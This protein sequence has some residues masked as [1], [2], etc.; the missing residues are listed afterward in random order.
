[1]YLLQ[2]KNALKVYRYDGCR[3]HKPMIQ[4]TDAALSEF[5]TQ[6]LWE[7]FCSHQPGFAIRYMVY[8]HY[9]SKKWVVKP[10][11][12][13]GVDFLLYPQGGASRGHAQF[14]VQI[15]H[16][17][18]LNASKHVD[19]PLPWVLSRVLHQVAKNFVMVSVEP[20]QKSEYGDSDVLALLANPPPSLDL[21]FSRF[22][23]LE[24]GISRFC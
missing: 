11:L 21:L 17:S 10:G 1:M 15:V 24:L 4:K 7:C 16:P 18:S 3:C 9:Q 22:T 19:R 14:G 6:S 12:K 20:T 13:L 8:H 23:L 2:A 5:S